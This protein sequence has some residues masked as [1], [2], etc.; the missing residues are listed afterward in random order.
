MTNAMLLMMIQEQFGKWHCGN[1]DSSLSEQYKAHKKAWLT[2][3]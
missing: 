3:E 2:A 1:L